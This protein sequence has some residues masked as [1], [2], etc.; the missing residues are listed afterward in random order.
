MRST[1]AAVALLPLIAALAAPAALRAQQSDAHFSG[2]EPSDWQLVVDGS[3]KPKARLFESQRARSI[4]ILSA[5]LASP[6][7][8]DIPGREV[9]TV[10]MLKVY[11]KPDGSID[12]LADATITPVAHFDIVDQTSA[13][14]TID[15]H[16]VLVKPA[17]WQLGH[18]TGAQLLESNAGYRY[19]AK[20]YEPDAQAIAHL[21]QT[22][23]PGEVTIL[24]FFGT[25]CPHC[26]QNLPK[27][28]KL[29]ERL[30]G[31]RLHFDYYGLPS[32]FNTE[33][34]AAKRKVTSVPTGMVLVDGEEI[35]R[36][37]AEQWSNPEVAL[38]QILN[39]AAKSGS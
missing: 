36:I 8:L 5:D 20:R 4:L 35:G 27:M 6:V 12:L 25:W 38:D 13:H 9:A 33:S 31:S 32:G 7:L 26:E 15:G 16:D 23:H 10:E 11:E 2:F 1:K 29:E 3:A 28:L 37:P 19:R 22:K 39:G 17:T 21:R 24:T 18:H 34:E 30:A 14:F